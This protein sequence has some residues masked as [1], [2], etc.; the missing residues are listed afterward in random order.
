MPNKNK[1]ALEHQRSLVTTI[2]TIIV[3]I[4]TI[5][6]ASSL[7]INL[8]IIAE[9]SEKQLQEKMN[10]HL[11]YL[12]ESLA[13]HLWNYDF[14]SIQEFGRAMMANDIVVVLSILDDSDKIIF[15][16]RKQPENPQFERSEKIMYRN[17]KVGSFKLGLNNFQYLQQ[18]KQIITVN[19]ITDIVNVPLNQY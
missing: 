18:R 6:S 8:S 12:Q 4:V 19:I 3:I 14:W 11:I 15:A 10:V 5:V 17:S 1:P 13:R 16:A 7:A 2:L 9:E